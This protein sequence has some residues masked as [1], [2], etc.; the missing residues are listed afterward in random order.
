[1]MIMVCL[2]RNRCAVEST[3]HKLRNADRVLKMAM[4]NSSGLQG[5][6]CYA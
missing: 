2:Q 1:M 6:M 4:K 5:S 3:V